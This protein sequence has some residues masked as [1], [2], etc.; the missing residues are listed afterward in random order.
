MRGDALIYLATIRDII[1][2][3]CLQVA[4]YSF[5]PTLTCRQETARSYDIKNSEIELS[6]PKLQSMQ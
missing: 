1:P 4:W 3:H 6:Q 2:R 5:K